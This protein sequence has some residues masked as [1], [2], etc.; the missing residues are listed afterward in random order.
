M[1]ADRCP[2]EWTSDSDTNRTSS[3]GDSASALS[4]PATV[5]RI[6]RPSHQSTAPTR[7]CEAC[8]SSGSQQAAPERGGPNA[9]G[10]DSVGDGGAVDPGAGDSM[11]TSVQAPSTLAGAQ[12]AV[13]TRR[14][15]VG[16][17]QDSTNSLDPLRVSTASGAS[18]EI[19]EYIGAG[20]RAAAAAAASSRQKLRYRASVSGPYTQT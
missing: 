13:P 15:A 8:R 2:P 12:F 19:L 1:R 14:H 4:S 7:P 17:A 20:A 6:P 18:T 5:D 10:A 11:S 9:D 3:E 16:G